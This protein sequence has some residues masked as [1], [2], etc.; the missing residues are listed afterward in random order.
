M[1]EGK[2]LDRKITVTKSSIS[3]YLGVPRF[4]HGEREEKSQVGLAT[5]LAWTELG[6]ELLMIEVA[7][8]DGSGKIEI[9]GKIGEVMQESAKAA[10]SYVR[11]RSELF[12]LKR[13]F[14]KEVDIHIH[15]PEGATPKDGP[16][17]GITM[18]T[19]LFQ[20]YSMFRLKM[21]LP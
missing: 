10:L 4:R 1:V 19:A 3:S 8:M 14:Y 15:V 16:S 9:T 6:G 13:D 18:A 17:A 11:T 5:G 7:I 21:M 12:G 2:D 20:L